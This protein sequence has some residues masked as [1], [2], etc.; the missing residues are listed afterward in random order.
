M[1]TNE[2]IKQFHMTRKALLVYENKGLIHPK[3]DMS[4][5]R[6][7]S[8]DDIKIIMKIILLRQ[9]DISLNEIEQILSGGV[10]WVEK[11]KQQYDLE[12]KQIQIKQSYLDYVNQVIC[13]Q[14]DANEA[15]RSLDESIKYENTHKN[16]SFHISKI[17]TLIIIFFSLLIILHTKNFDMI[18]TMGLVIF[19][20]LLK[21]LLETRYSDIS[22]SLHKITSG[23]LLLAG[24]SGIYYYFQ[25]KDMLIL[26]MLMI[27]CVYIIFY[28]IFKQEKVR[29]FLYHHRK[30]F[31]LFSMI[32]ILIPFVMTVLNDVYLRYDCKH[33][34]FFVWIFNMIFVIKINSREE[35]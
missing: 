26:T 33:F 29:S 21:S 32:A 1:K 5:Y 28:I 25:A 31:D 2:V 22:L 24:I 35:K 19:S 14:Y 15:I 34:L 12:K 13:D 9:F 27:F 17:S 20:L 6:D 18:V 8:E 10:Q 11:L 4:G 16:Q 7:Y 3:R 30:Y 23:L